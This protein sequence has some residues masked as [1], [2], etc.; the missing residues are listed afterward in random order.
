MLLEFRIVVK[1]PE[2]HNHLLL[3]PNIVLFP[4]QKKTR[5]MTHYVSF[6]PLLTGIISYFLVIIGTALKKKN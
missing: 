1:I 5:E 4:E 3:L 6:Q 2:V